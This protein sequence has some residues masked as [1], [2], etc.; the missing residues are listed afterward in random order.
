MDILRN[1]Q[2][3]DQG[4]VLKRDSIVLHQRGAPVRRQILHV[5]AVHLDG[6]GIR[7]PQAQ[8]R[9]Q[10]YRLTRAGAADDP[11]YL[12]RLH[13]HVQALVNDLRA[14]AVLQAAH[15]NDRIDFGLGHQKSIFTK[16][17]ANSASAR[18]TMKIDWTTATVVKRPSS[19]A[20]S[21]TCIPR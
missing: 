20:D 12:I 5:F 7:T 15:S 17:M 2:G 16:R 19:R 21:R 14:K 6:A 1:C 10:Q 4:A 8:D 13:L 3:A 9:A 18:M 11:E